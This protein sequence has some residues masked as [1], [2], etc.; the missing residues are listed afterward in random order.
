MSKDPKIAALEGAVNVNGDT[1]PISR[2]PIQRID[3]TEWGTM[4]RTKLFNQREALDTR[5]SFA[6]F[7]IISSYRIW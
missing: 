3:S 7:F 5:L 1:T 4:G 6:I 2:Q